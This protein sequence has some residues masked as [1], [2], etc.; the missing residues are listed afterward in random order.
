MTVEDLLQSKLAQ[1]LIKPLFPEVV[2]RS[3]RQLQR[4][5]SGK[6][7]L[8][9]LHWARVVYHD[10]WKAFLS[11][12]PTARL[13]L[14]EVSPGPMTTWRGLGWASYKGVQYPEFDITKEALPEQFDVIVA[15]QI[16]E[17]LRH[18]YAAARNVRAMLKDDGVFLIATPFLIRVHE[19]PGDYTRWTKTG[20]A[21]LLEDSGFTADARS[22]GNR[23]C[24]I[25]NFDE[26]EFFKK[27]RDLTHEPNFPITVWAYARKNKA[28]PSGAP[29]T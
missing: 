18:P 23:K 13:S 8:T 16:F 12:L 24:V 10:E 17:H 28:A 9:D 1:A 2:R 5:L 27:G 26:W 25:A 19:E 22:W 21:G 4:W 11:S 29:P 7:G 15:E 6:S 14:L 20:L 3:G